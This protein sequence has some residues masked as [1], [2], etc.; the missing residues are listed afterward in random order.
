MDMRLQMLLMLRFALVTLQLFASADI[1]VIEKHL[2]KKQLNKDLPY[3]TSTIERVHP[4]NCYSISKQKY[5]GLTE[6]VQNA[7]PDGMT[8][9]QAWPFMARLVGNERA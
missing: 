3:L 5:Q 2:T 4:Y 6:S 8:E 1:T 9:R 7:L